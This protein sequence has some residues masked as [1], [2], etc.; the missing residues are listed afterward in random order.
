MGNNH[1]RNYR[2]EFNQPASDG[3]R[4]RVHAFE[5]H[6]LRNGRFNLDRFGGFDSDSFG[7]TRQ[8]RDKFYLQH[9][10][11]DGNFFGCDL[12]SLFNFKSFCSAKF[13]VVRR[14]FARHDA[15]IFD[16]F[17]LA[18]VAVFDV[19]FVAT[20]IRTD[21]QAEIVSRGFGII[22]AS[23]ALISSD[24]IG[25]C[26]V[27]K[28]YFS[29]SERSRKICS[30]FRDLKKFFGH[31]V[32]VIKSGISAA[33]STGLISIKIWAI[34]QIYNTHF[35]L[36]LGES[37]DLE[38]L[39]AAIEKDFA[40]YPSMFVRIVERDGETFREFVVENFHQTVERMIED[41]WQ[42]N[43]LKSWR[44]L[45]NFTAA[46]YFVSIWFRPNAQNIFCARFTTFASTAR[47]IIFFSTTPQ[48]FTLPRP[49]KPTTK[50]KRISAT[51]W[52][53]LVALQKAEAVS[54][55]DANTLKNLKR[56]QRQPLGDIVL[57]GATGYLGF[58]IF[59]EFIGNRA[60]KIY[61]L[62]RRKKICRE[63]TQSPAVLLFRPNLR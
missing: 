49:P 32:D 23:V 44:R 7:Q 54:I 18:A 60:G 45:L 15:R 27:L 28:K 24:A 39:A 16:C 48:N 30:V 35:L 22:G 46:D 2:W 12:G 52:R 36:T 50:S 43:C 59:H 10:H 55:V 25:I 31:V 53:E 13:F 14:K 5:S 56:G 1:Q 37:I 47:A 17:R 21:G 42:K 3:G 26:Y 51:F 9:G 6:Y 61:C 19:L 11:S 58:Y 62:L 38:R 29:S 41:A 40:S 33:C 20:L 8:R 63:A 57:A 4:E 34:Y